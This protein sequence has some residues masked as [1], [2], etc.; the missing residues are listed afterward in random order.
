MA[1]E[2]LAGNKLARYSTVVSKARTADLVVHG[3]IGFRGWSVLAH[4]NTFYCEKPE[5]YR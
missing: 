3:P 4:D 2:G 1:T 5:A